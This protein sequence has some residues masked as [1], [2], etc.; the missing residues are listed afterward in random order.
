MA[1]T[2]ILKRKVVGSSYRL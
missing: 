2:A 1:T